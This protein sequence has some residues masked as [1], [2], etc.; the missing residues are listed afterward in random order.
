MKLS[1]KS[2]AR[3]RRLLLA[4]ASAA[5]AVA[6]FVVEENWRGNR[7]WAAYQRDLMARGESVDLA[8]FRPAA[9]PDPLNFFKQP[10]LDRLFNGRKENP[11]RQK[12]IAGLGLE[13]FIVT[14]LPIDFSKV[15]AS[16]K[17]LGVLSFP[18]SD[19]PAADV[20]KAMQRLDP[21]FEALQEAALF[22]PAAVLE[23]D[24]SSL[25]IVDPNFAYQ[26]GQTL[27][28]HAQANLA[29]D[30]VERAYADTFTLFRYANSLF[31]DSTNL[32]ALLVAD[33]VRGLAAST[34]KQG[35]ER[36]LWNDSQLAAFQHLFIAADPLKKFGN[37]VRA[38]RA[39]G[40]YF[41]DANPRLAGAD[42][43][44]PAWLFHGWIQQNK[45][46]FHRYSDT[47]VLPAFSL[48]SK[49]NFTTRLNDL[50]LA[51]KRIK[52]SRSPFG[53][54]SRLA[55]SNLEGIGE[56]YGANASKISN[57]ATLCALERHRL[58]HGHF[59]EKL[60][61]LVPTYLSEVP[62]DIFTDEPV[63]YR[64]SPADGGRLY[65]AGPNGRDDDGKYDDLVLTLPAEK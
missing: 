54:L 16:L 62:R 41:F 32:L 35:C 48:N 25:P 1:P 6:I 33:G 22:R 58:A 40:I 45:V 63:N 19:R 8:T 37:M 46:S 11:D 51:S 12:F 39:A 14:E 29:N 59:P 7:A 26:V 60:E 30:D 34:I 64:F 52:K 43:M 53:V 20:L 36:R 5:T 9:V 56:S 31:A 65:S 18:E 28:V 42:E 10:L 49:R 2:I 61:S 27:A 55:L 3:V 47:E 15:R 13:N 38:E 57:V 17:R 23:R 21:L 24:N 44:I 4:L 50:K